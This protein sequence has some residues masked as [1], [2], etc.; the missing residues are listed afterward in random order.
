MNVLTREFHCA[1]F[2]GWTPN[3][4]YE[5]IIKNFWN[6]ELPYLQLDF[7]LNV[8]EIYKEI[9]EVDQSAWIETQSQTYARQKSIANNEHWFFN[10]HSSGWSS[11]H[12]EPEN[13]NDKKEQMHK[14]IITNPHGPLMDYKRKYTGHMLSYRC[15]ELLKSPYFKKITIS[16]LP[17]GGWIQPHK[18]Q[19]MV[20][21]HTLNYMWIPLNE[22]QENLKIYPY[23]YMPC[24]VGK[25]YLLNNFDFIHSVINKDKHDRYVL[26]ITLKNCEEFFSRHNIQKA[27]KEQW[28]S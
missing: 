20:K 15:L 12:I 4:S 19:Y 13:V 7:A 5:T 6:S 9:L 26:L 3:K 22:C 27:V 21:E 1:S 11:I 24:Q 23:G 8:R 28:F 16:R 17:P 25:S 14:Q 18:D 2:P 10:P